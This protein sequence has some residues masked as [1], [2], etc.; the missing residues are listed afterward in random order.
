MLVEFDIKHCRLAFI[1]LSP[2]INLED[3]E[4]KILNT[5]DH[6]LFKHMIDKMMF[7][8]I[9]IKVD[10]ALAINWLSQY[11]SKSQEIHLQVTKHLLQCLANAINLEILYTADDEDLTIYADAAY[12]NTHKFKSTTEYCT[13]IANSSVI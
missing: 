13:L 10:I 3:Q 9:K 1:S 6:E 12:T 4:S 8:A 5:K 2:S 11:L 7:V